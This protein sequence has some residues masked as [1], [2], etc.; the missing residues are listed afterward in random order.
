MIRIRNGRPVSAVS[1]AA[2]TDLVGRFEQA[3]D[4]LVEQI[5]AESADR[6]SYAVKRAVV[7]I[8]LLSVAF[9]AVGGLLLS[10][11]RRREH[12]RRAR[13]R[14]VP[15]LPA[16]VRGDAAGDGERE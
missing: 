9:A 16:R 13:R 10:R 5:E 1:T 4:S 6:H 12:D 7:L 2:R 11:M 3:N 8:V 15:R 14:R